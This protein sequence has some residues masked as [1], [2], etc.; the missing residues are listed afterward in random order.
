MVI[1]LSSFV[2]RDM[3][4]RYHW[5][6]GIGHTYA[7]N[8]SSTESLLRS[9]SQRTQP[10]HSRRHDVEDHKCHVDDEIDES[11]DADST[12]TEWDFE[13]DSECG[14]SQSDESESIL[15]DLADMYGCGSDLDALYTF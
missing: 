8:T 7:H 10:L 1:P 2:D 6:L 5:G 9:T 14:E 4:M 3:L 12:E 13:Q 15:G 11:G